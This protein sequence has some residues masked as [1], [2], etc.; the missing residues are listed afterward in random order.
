MLLIFILL[1]IAAHMSPPLAFAV[2]AM[3]LA[4]AHWF[5]TFLILLLGL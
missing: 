3:T 4:S 5:I 2:A 1:Y